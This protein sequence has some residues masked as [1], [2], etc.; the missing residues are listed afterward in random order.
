MLKA[1]QSAKMAFFHLSQISVKFTN[2]SSVDFTITGKRMAQGYANFPG[3]KDG[4]GELLEA[5]LNR[6]KLLT[7]VSRILVEKVFL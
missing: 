5:H 4:P 7:S 6:L 1:Q 3:E 2:D